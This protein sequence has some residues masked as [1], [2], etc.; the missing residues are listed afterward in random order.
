[1]L[2]VDVVTASF[3]QVVM[4]LPFL[5]ISFWVTAF[6]EMQLRTGNL[7]IG[8]PPSSIPFPLAFL[9][10]CPRSESLYIRIF[11]LSYRGSHSP[12]DARWGQ[13]EPTS[14]SNERSSCGWPAGGVDRHDNS[15]DSGSGAEK[16]V[17][18]WSSFS[19]CQRRLDRG[20]Y[21]RSQGRSD[22]RAMPIW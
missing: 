7:K 5:M 6:K 1:M 19:S 3:S 15:D 11:Q 14:S 2:Q 8:T 10:P 13:D 17:C 20:R 21:S 12:R 18:Q 16:T 9:P 22:G 4:D